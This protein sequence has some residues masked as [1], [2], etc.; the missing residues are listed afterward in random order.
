MILAMRKMGRQ[1]DHIAHS[2][3]IKFDICFVRIS[4]EACCFRLFLH[5]WTISGMWNNLNHVNLI[6]KQCELS[7]SPKMPTGQWCQPFLSCSDRVPV[8]CH[9]EWQKDSNRF[10]DFEAAFLYPAHVTSYKTKQRTR[11]PISSSATHPPSTFSWLPIFILNSPSGNHRER[12]M[13][14]RGHRLN[15]WLPRLRSICSNYG[16][17]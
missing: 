6:R 11:A 15:P 13:N 2:D 5:R 14:D 12:A 8:V 4:V 1:S 16:F 3:K 9:L 7:S 10:A 17:T